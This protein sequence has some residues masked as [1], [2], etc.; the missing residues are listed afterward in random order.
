LF[1]RR[2]EK[3]ALKPDGSPVADRLTVPLKPSV[4]VIWRMADALPQGYGQKLSG[5]PVL[6]TGFG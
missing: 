6:S 3:M 1:E 2:Y 4:L 5:I